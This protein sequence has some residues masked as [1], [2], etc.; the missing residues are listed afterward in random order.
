M[1]KSDKLEIINT[2]MMYLNWRGIGHTYTMVNGVK[3]NESIVI[4]NHHQDEAYISQMAGKKI[5]CIPLDRVR[6]QL[7]GNRLPLAI[8][9]FALSHL[10]SYVFD[11]IRDYQE[12]NDELKSEI[13][14]YQNRKPLRR[15]VKSK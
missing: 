8:D 12:E 9:N 5:K 11:I 4:T 2:I 1:D 14:E 3:N 10:L 7:R 6:E 15:T 13:R